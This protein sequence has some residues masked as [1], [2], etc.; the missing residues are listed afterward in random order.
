M[1]AR[2]RTLSG[3]QIAVIAVLAL[4]ASTSL[5]C[6]VVRLSTDGDLLVARNHDWPF[7]EGLVVVNQPGLEKKGVSPVNPA[8]WVA[9]YGSVT[10]T[11]FGREFPFAGMNERGLTIDLLQLNDAEFPAA[12]SQITTVNVVQWVQ[13]QLDTAATVGEVLASLDTVLPTPL[14]PAVERVHYFVTDPEGGVAIIEFLDGKPVIQHGQNVEQCAL[15]NSA[16]TD[17]SQSLSSNPAP[18]QWRYQ[19]A[20][21]AIG[22][23][24]PDTKTAKSIDYAF[25]TLSR[26]AQDDLTQ[27][28]LV[29]LPRDRRI[30]FQTKQSPNRRWID[31]DDL[32]FRQGGIAT[33][34]DVDTT[35]RGDL[36]KHLV[37]YTTAANERIVNNAFDRYMPPGFARTAVKQLVL[38]YAASLEAA[39]AVVVAPAQ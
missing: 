8:C 21:K 7:G 37:D 4:S 9:D 34:I 3:R 18:N 19:L 39:G 12:T 24:K 20:V 16:W 30:Y 2:L 26:V 1:G 35:Q 5:A 25:D 28:Q 6:T 33:V 31:L 36:S 17:S 22:E 38:D 27:W 14:L 13:Y 29:Y 32:E 10:F 15:A 23:L 11:Q